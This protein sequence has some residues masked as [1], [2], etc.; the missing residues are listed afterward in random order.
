MVT[1][2]REPH[3]ATRLAVAA[4][5]VAAGVVITPIGTA[6]ACSCDAAE[7]PIVDQIG[8]ADLVFV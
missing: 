8:E 5:L 2:T 4:L 6:S 1:T 7:V 3:L